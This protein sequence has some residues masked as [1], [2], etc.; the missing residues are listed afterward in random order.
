MNELE[1]FISD[2]LPRTHTEDV[3]QALVKKIMEEGT[4]PNLIFKIGEA[5]G[6]LQASLNN[7]T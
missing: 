3:R 5:W 6:R 2:M 4:N 7:P 1:K